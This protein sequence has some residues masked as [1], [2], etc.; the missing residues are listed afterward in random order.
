MSEDKGEPTLEEPYL[1]S[2]R[3][4]AQWRARNPFSRG[5]CS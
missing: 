5:R 4:A 2:F 3:G 1:P